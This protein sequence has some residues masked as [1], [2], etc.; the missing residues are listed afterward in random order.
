MAISRR[1]LND[2]ESVLVSTRTHMK[3]LIGP[4]LVLMLIAAVALVAISFTGVAGRAQP[5]LVAVVAAVAAALI[6]VWVAKPFLRWLT[7][8]YTVTTH[9]LITRSGILAR[10]G[11][12][13]PLIRISDVSYEH[14]LLD[15]VLGC[16]TLV[17]SDASEQ[18]RVVLH[19]IPH[20]ERVHLT[21]SEQL[22]DNTDTR[23]DL[24]GSRHRTDDGS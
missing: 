7:T 16:G 6:A 17:I 10:R 14:G 23:H 8:S 18:G 1:L 2:D 20:V 15:R 3:A 4:L 22:F 12:D 9:R 5:L 11:H 13:I 24:H 19:D 21:I